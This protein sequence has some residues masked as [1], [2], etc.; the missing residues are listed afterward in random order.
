LPFVVNGKPVTSPARPSMRAGTPQFDKIVGDTHNRRLSIDEA[1]RALEVA[2]DIK[3]VL[4][5]IE[6]ALTKYQS[7][8][9]M[10]YTAS[11]RRAWVTAVEYIVNIFKSKSER[12]FPCTHRL[13]KGCVER[14]E[15]KLDRNSSSE[16]ALRGTAGHMRDYWFQLHNHQLSLRWHNKAEQTQPQTIF[17]VGSSEPVAAGEGMVAGLENAH[18]DYD[19]AV[20]IMGS[21]KEFVERQTQ[22]HS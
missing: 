1:H 4:Q 5:S 14:V 16:L 21:L 2:A 17:Q 15:W 6:H 10:S 7:K 12:E 20:E 3:S 9:F 22:V 13:H 19:R 11:P 18:V 8:T